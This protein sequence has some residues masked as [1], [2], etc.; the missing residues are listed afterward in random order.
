MAWT[1]IDRDKEGKLI[2][3]AI[4]RVYVSG[5]LAFIRVI[6]KPG[7]GKSGLCIRIAELLNK[8]LHKE[9]KFE[10]KYIVDNLEDLIKLVMETKKEDKRVIIIEEM[11]ALFN[12]RRFMQ[13]ENI[14]ANALLDTMRKRGIIL[15][16]NYPIAKTVDTH[17]EK[18]LCGDVQAIRIDKVHKE[19]F[20]DYRIMDT[21][22]GTGKTYRRILRDQYGNEAAY[23]RFNWCDKETFEKYD[24][25]KDLFMKNLYEHLLLKN[26][27][28]RLEQELNKLK[29]EKMKE[30]VEKMND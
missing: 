7:T 6:G 10:T 13:T 27:K 28:K 4:L 8:R 25:G 3:D 21:S 14:T 30:K 17:I 24:E 9:E 22:P 1:P 2:I 15:I 20:V 11:S 19:Y 12:N 16:G 18:L 23:F 5:K 26:E 29:V